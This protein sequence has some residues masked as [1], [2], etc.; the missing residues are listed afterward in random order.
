MIND[1]TFCSPLPPRLEDFGRLLEH[2]AKSRQ[3]SFWL[4]AVERK[5]RIPQGSE[6]TQ[7]VRSDIVQVPPV[8]IGTKDRRLP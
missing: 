6:P 7:T 2:G 3:D 4:L 5:H 8:R 1:M